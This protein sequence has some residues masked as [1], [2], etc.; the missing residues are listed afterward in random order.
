MK[1]SPDL[2][3]AIQDLWSMIAWDVGH[4]DSNE[5]AV[6]ICIDAD[7]LMTYG[8]PQEDQEVTHLIQQYDYP[9][10]LK[11]LSREIQLT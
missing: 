3:H 10:V 5:E 7:R 1:I 11:A 8:F 4:C 6:E 9:T 2:K